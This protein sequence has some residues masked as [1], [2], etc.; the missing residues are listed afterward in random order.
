M[1]R[2]KFLRSDVRCSVAGLVAAGYREVPGR[3]NQFGEYVFFVHD[4]QTPQ[5]LEEAYEILDKTFFFPPYGVWVDGK[6][7]E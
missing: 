6:R 4:S 2:A 7:L 5:T 1:L 3:G